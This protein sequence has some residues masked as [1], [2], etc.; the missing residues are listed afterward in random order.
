MFF[1]TTNKW[2]LKWT[3]NPDLIITQCK[4]T[5]KTLVNICRHVMLIKTIIKKFLKSTVL[6]VVW[7]MDCREWA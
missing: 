6:A 7:G 1:L 2:C 4:Y 3:D 5:G